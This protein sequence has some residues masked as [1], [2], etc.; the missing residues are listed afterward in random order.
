M[1]LHL[2]LW[3]IQGQSILTAVIL[4]T[5]DNLEELR[6]DL[7]GGLD[8]AD[9]GDNILG[10]ILGHD[11]GELLGLLVLLDV[12][13]TE[14]HLDGVQEELD[15]LTVLSE[16]GSRSDEALLAGELSER[17]TANTLIGILE[18]RVADTLEDLVDIGLLR[19]LVD[20]MLGNDEVLGLLQS[21]ADLGEDLLVLESVVDGA[22]ATVVAVVSSGSVAGVDSEQL[23]LDEGGE[24]FDPVDALDLR[25]AN[26]L[27]GSLVNNPLEELLEG[28]VEASIGVLRGDNAV[29]SGVGV[30]G[31]QMVVFETLG[32]SVLGVLDVL[33][34]G[35]G[36]TDGVL[37]GNDMEGRLLSGATVDTLGDDGSDKAEDVGA[38]GAGNDVCS[39]DLLDQI[40]L[41]GL[42]VDG[43]VV[44]D[45]V[46][47][48]ALGADLDDLV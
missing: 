46:L 17:G 15:G 44:G 12:L 6:V 2:R 7:L 39:A 36:G 37:T 21:T 34:E 9:L 23:A 13:E 35:V 32:S 29:N 33:G 40:L 18:M 41:V 42:G 22:L 8:A 47:G 43:A 14:S 28:H 1:P 31:T 19:L 11:L 30:A 45:G 20:A 27:K 38:D 5:L 48:G 4:H 3:R 25:D 10:A 26:I 24:V 16:L